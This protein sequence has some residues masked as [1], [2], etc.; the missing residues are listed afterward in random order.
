MN[1]ISLIWKCFSTDAGV[2]AAITTQRRGEGG[3][4][5]GNLFEAEGGT[6]SR[7]ELAGKSDARAPQSADAAAAS[8]KAE[9]GCCGTL[10]T[11]VEASSSK[12]R[13]CRLGAVVALWPI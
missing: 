8:T 5:T 7:S 9:L 1:P 4:H 11:R 12:S 6:S 3:R 10:H 13:G 2:N